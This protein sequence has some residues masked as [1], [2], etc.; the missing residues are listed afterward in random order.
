MPLPAP[1]SLEGIR[2]L[3]LSRILAA[4]SITQL[5]G[6]LGADVVK[7]E[8][9]GTGDDTRSWGPPYVRDA[10]GA[11]TDLSAYFL[12]ANR[13]KRSIA[14][15]LASEA[16]AD[17]IKR[18]AAQADV[19]V[20]NYKPGDL[21]R[22]G[23]DYDAIRQVKPDIIWCS[24][25]GFGQTGPYADRVGYDF[26]VQA[27]GGI[28][29]ITGAP[30]EQGGE[31][32]KVG[33]GVADLMCGM[34][35]GVGILAALRHRDRTGEGQFI[36]ISLFDTQ[37]AWLVN[38]ATNYLVSGKRPGRLGNQHPNIVPYQPFRAADGYLCVAVGNDRQ[39]AA[40]CEVIG[41]P[42]LAADDRFH[43]NPSRV[44][45]RKAL[46]ALLAPAIA[47]RPVNE[48]TGALLA[49]GVPAG[50]L[51]SVD[52][53]LRDEHTLARGMV[54]EMEDEQAAAKLRLLGNP[55]HMSAT[56]P[57]YRSPP[58]HLNA[59]RDSVLGDWLALDAVGITRLEESG[60]FGGSVA[61]AAE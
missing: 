38:A 27:M 43:A 58:P 10:E 59:D 4:P 21:A 6:D 25:T 19:V 17:L 29:S 61:K 60:A 31:P 30:E 51:L 32:T 9:P 23:L 36:D 48:W 7:V 8:R 45:N 18:L 3:D 22:K 34:Y 52:E 1:Q 33:V 14:I 35:A 56:P 53:A 39:F 2:I 11:D 42:E 12:C 50:P 15:D 20:E 5:F 40:F 46:E 13:N 57:S 28:M 16:G 26:L 37:I 24:V 44:K 41:L 54:I 49:V 47:R 55:L